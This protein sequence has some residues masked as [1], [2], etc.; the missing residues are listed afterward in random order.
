MRQIVHNDL[1]IA[2]NYTWKVIAE[3][4]SGFTNESYVYSFT[5]RTTII[6][7]NGR[8]Y[9]VIKVNDKTWMTE[10]LS[11]QTINSWCYDGKSYNC[12]EYGR[13]YT[14]EDANNACPEGWHLPTRNEWNELQN[15]HTQL[16]LDPIN[17]RLGGHRKETG[18]YLQLDKACYYWTESYNQQKARCLIIFS[19]GRVKWDI[20]SKKMGLSVRCIKN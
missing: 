16:L 11:Y 5:T 14:W 15:K 19:D 18:E 7:P 6:D 8:D 17:A 12:N 20:I 9:K 1:K 13:L 2:T 10:N 4:N 3:D